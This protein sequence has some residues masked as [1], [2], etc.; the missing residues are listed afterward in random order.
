MHKLGLKTEQFDGVFKGLSSKV[1]RTASVTPKVWGPAV[2]PTQSEDSSEVKPPVSKTPSGLV[3]P[4]AHS[5]RLGPII[6]DENGRR[7]DKEL[8][9]DQDV[10]DRIKKGHLCYSFYLRGECS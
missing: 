9:V 7:V 8:H 4:A 6:R 3:N 10:V 2:Y 1:S 5:S